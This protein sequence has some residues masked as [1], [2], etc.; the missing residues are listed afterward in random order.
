MFGWILLI[1]A[2]IVILSII[3]ACLAI[4]SASDYM[5]DSFMSDKHDDISKEDKDGE[6]H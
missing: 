6:E 2:I 1:M 4:A 3:S 5:N